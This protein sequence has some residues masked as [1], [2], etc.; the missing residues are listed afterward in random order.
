MALTLSDARSRLR[1][2]YLDDSPSGKRWDTASLNRALYVAAVGVMEE[3]ALIKI[4][5][6]ERTYTGTT[7]SGSL[8]VPKH[9]AIR[10][11]YANVGSTK[12]ALR[13][14]DFAEVTPSVQ[15]SLSVVYLPGITEPTADG[16]YLL[17]AP[18]NTALY[19]W[20]VLEE[21]VLANAALACFAKE[22][23]PRVAGAERASAIYRGQVL[24]SRSTP[25]WTKNAAPS[26]HAYEDMFR[27]SYNPE[28]GSVVLSGVVL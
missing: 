23:N 4:P 28:A 21:W 16:H 2:E 26:W 25:G 3:L 22:P 19:D 1:A 13:A 10:D 24:E 9:T 5:R 12:I 15:L 8:V 17:N 6:L 14:A 20:P 18:D 11:V 7:T 27:W